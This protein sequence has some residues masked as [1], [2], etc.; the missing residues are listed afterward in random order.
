MQNQVSNALSWSTHWL[1]RDVTDH[2]YNSIS[3]DAL[4]TTLNAKT[5]A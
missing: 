1:C 3:T 4:P 5:D 2:K